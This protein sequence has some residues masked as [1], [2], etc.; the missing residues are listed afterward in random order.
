MTIG[1][2]SNRWRNWP[3]S[4]QLRA[5][6]SAAPTPA[7]ATAP[8][9]R[10]L[11]R[12]PA[13][14]CLRPPTRPASPVPPTRELRPVPILRRPGHQRPALLPGLRPPA[15]RSA[16]A[17]H[18]RRRLHGRDEAARRSR[19]R[20]RR[21]KKQRRISPNAALIAGVGT[22]L[23]A[24]GIGVLIGRSGDDNGL[25]PAAGADRDQGRRRR[26]SERPPRR[27]RATIGGAA[28]P[29]ASR[30]KQSSKQKKHG[31]GNRRRGRRSPEAEAGREAAAADHR[32]RRQVRK[33]HA[34]VAEKRR[35]RRQLLRRM[36]I[37]SGA[38]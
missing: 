4:G 18:G 16:P 35:I 22:L 25:R 2:G 9:R 34:P 5:S 14:G 36:T 1:R 27:R 26:R 28:A 31:R 12:S 3:W 29:R 30:R 19:S 38:R 32:S 13:P 8:I 21:P 11:N 20:R 15:R 37:A 10:A 17:V 6:S 23:L 7:T 24:L 33:G